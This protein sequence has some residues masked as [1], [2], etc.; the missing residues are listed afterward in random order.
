MNAA[1]IDM[2]AAEMNWAADVD[3]SMNALAP[4]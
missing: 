2:N 1:E 3:P 4:Q